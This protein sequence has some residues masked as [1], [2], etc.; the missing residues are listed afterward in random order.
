MKHHNTT[1]TSCT[2]GTK[3]TTYNNNNNSSSKV[4]TTTSCCCPHHRFNNCGNGGY[5]RCRS[6]IFGYRWGIGIVLI[7]WMIYTFYYDE[8]NLFQK[9][10]VEND[11]NLSSS[12]SS[13]MVVEESNHHHYRTN[14]TTTTSSSSS[15]SSSTTDG[16]DTTHTETTLLL[17]LLLRDEP[18]PGPVWIVHDIFQM[19]TTLCQSTTNLDDGSDSDGGNGH[20]IIRDACDADSTG[21][22]LGYL[23]LA[24]LY[25]GQYH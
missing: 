3:T 14:T 18:Q 10:Q 4:T 25:A 15:S 1:L 16:T 13:L 19:Y 5:G 20:F 2:V 17:Q 22:V 11:D 23:F 7:F 8:V 12:S 6:S 9:Y 24:A 21:N